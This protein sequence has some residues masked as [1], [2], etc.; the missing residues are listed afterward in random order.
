MVLAAAVDAVL[1][2]PAITRSL[3]AA[4]A[5]DPAALLVGAPPVVGTLIS[6]LRARGAD[7]PDPSCTRCGRTGKPLTR[8]PSG[9]VCARCRRRQLAAA[10][11]RCGVVKPVAGRDAQNEPV[12]ARCAD[13]PQ[14]P[15]GRCGRTR[16]IAR[17]AHDGIPDICD[18]CF[19]LPEGV[20]SRCQQLRPCS[21]ANGPE[22]VCTRCAARATA[23][24][25]HCGADRPPTARW[26]EGPVCDPCYNAA[27]RRR[28]TC[29]TCGAMRRLVAPPGPD[30]TTCAD[31]A[32]TPTTAHTCT[33][34]G[35]EDKLYEKGRC[36]P[37][38]LRRRTAE[39]L[40]G[41]AKQVPPALAPVYQAITTTDA[42]RTALNWLRNSAGAGLL[43]EM[44]SGTTDISHETLDAHPRAA[45][46]GYLRAV[47]V[48]NNVLPARDEQLAAAERFLTR[49]LAGIPNDADRRLVHAYATWRV[50]RRLRSSTELAHRERS[51][52][53]HAHLN[54]TAAADL[55]SWLRD[56]ETTLN[57]IGAGDIEDY[58]TGATARYQVRDFLQWAAAGRHA[59]HLDVPTLAWAPGQAATSDERW[60]QIAR[61]LHDDTIQTTD[62]VA[63]SLLLLYGQQLSR[64]AALTLDQVKT[65]GPQVFL[66]L[67][68]DDLHIPEPLAG[69][70]TTLTR[71][72]RPY[73]GVGSPP[74]TRWLF[75]GLQPG[76]P[77]TAARLGARLRKLGIRAQPG[78][79]A[80]LTHLAAQLPAAVLADLLGIHPTTAVN[81]VH[82]AGGDWNRYAAQLAHSGNHQP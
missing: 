75:P 38:A 14:R 43:A 66:H 50:L 58:L 4:L 32:G 31:C 6:E 29:T 81:W 48:A 39:L 68:R 71:D 65:Q 41:G 69:L 57:V 33:G 59:Q 64:T 24:C 74:T 45:A 28:G 52:T 21:F 60:A 20:C 47:L 63:G 54:I 19:R 79:R 15:C 72:G 30:A 26:P 42:P 44:A 82:D 36:A 80:A 17:R 35:L 5:A 13:R 76:R 40:A 7:L 73:V 10:C 3:A 77:L 78:R 67:G 12:C 70:L 23:V 37:C 46:A 27:L 51:Y 22:P 56:H 62:R 9:G 16:P 8:S 55:L 2:G 25:A 49:T 1:T 53:R 61:L 18:G 11:V 34:C